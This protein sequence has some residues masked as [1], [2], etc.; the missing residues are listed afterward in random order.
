MCAHYSKVCSTRRAFL[1]ELFVYE[2][3]YPH[4]ANLIEISNGNTLILS[5]L[6][7]I[8]Y[9]DADVITEE[10]II[11]LAKA[12]GKF[13]SL[14]QVDGKVLCHWDN[15]P[16]NI[17]WSARN[18]QIYL[19]DFED[20]RLAYPEADLTH[21]FLFWAEVMNADEFVTNVQT[22]L[23]HY[24]GQ[25]PL[26]INRWN[27]EYRKTKARFDRR[28]RKYSKKEKVANPFGTSNRKY[29]SKIEL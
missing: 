22:F 8:P 4:K 12:I 6:D 28:R 26:D 13:H 1:N 14:Q 2:S 25:I 16:R 19:L 17:L 18:K 21:L 29:L 10:I 3:A 7:G 27:A 9:L 15:Q 20:I 5:R 11:K 23:H 24:R